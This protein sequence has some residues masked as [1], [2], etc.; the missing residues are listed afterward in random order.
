MNAAR[1]G[2]LDDNFV[3]PVFAGTE[4]GGGKPV[5]ARLDLRQVSRH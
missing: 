3:I 1:S 4:N 5:S 2:A